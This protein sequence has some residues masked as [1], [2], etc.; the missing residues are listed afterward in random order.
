MKHKIFATTLLLA[1]SVSPVW[2]DNGSHPQNKAA[3]ASHQGSGKVVSIDREKLKVKL[4]H[5]PIASLNWP[6]MTMDFA[7]TRAALLDK[8][9]P[10]MQIIFTLVQ[11]EKPG[12]WVIDKVSRK[13]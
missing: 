11:G 7:V 4:E 10:G 12:S 13:P 5:G 8:L 9:Q 3:Q 6:G 2:A 1:L